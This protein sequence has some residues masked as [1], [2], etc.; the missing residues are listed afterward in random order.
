MNTIIKQYFVDLLRNNQKIYRLSLRIYSYINRSSVVFIDEEILISHNKKSIKLNIRNIT[1]V[2]EIVDYFD[3]YYDAVISYNKLDPLDFSKQTEH[4]LANVSFSFG[5][6]FSSVP[7]PSETSTQYI[8]ILK[9]KPGDTILDLGSYCGLTVID[10]LLSVGNEG[11]VLGVEAD[12]NNFTCLKKNLEK[13]KKEYAG[14]NF[15]LENVAISDKVG[16]EYFSNNQDMSSAIVDISPILHQQ[17]NNFTKVPATTVSELCKKY[18]L[19]EIDIIKADIEGSE[20]NFLKDATFFE[21]YNPKILLEPISL[22][23][24]NSLEEIYDYMDNYGYKVKSYSQ[25]GAKV[26][27]YLFERNLK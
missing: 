23:G 5:L 16:F 13:F 1:Y 25:E 22:K 26:P 11:F 20:I 24:K 12:L 4:K 17:K 14:Y 3:F 10:F 8:E 15:E 9:P 7:T 21:N 2:K 6:D 19:R 18:N 27:L